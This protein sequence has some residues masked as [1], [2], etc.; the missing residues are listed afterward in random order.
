MTV[1]NI[2]SDVIPAEMFVDLLSAV[3]KLQNKANN[4]S[5]RIEDKKNVYQLDGLHV[6]ILD[7]INLIAE[8]IGREAIKS[9]TG[10]NGKIISLLELDGFGGYAPLHQMHRG[11]FLG[12]HVDHTYACDGKLVH[13]GNSI[14]YAISRWDE[15]WGGATVFFDRNG[16][17]LLGRVMPVP[18]SMV[19]FSHDCESFHGVEKISCPQGVI[20]TTIYMDYYI[21]FEDLKDFCQIYRKKTNDKFLYSQYLTTFLP[22]VFNDGKLEVNSILNKNFFGYLRNYLGY[23]SAK[24]KNLRE[25]YKPSYIYYILY[26]LLFLY[27]L[28]FRNFKKLIKAR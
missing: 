28:T 15:S 2:Q 23:C 10:W 11:G 12:S 4:L 25:S 19:V 1:F 14:Y 3:E 9:L 8:Q 6:A 22:V 20:R 21:H 18:N 7:P 17:D 13:I 5:T 26:S 27:D 16:V 24:R